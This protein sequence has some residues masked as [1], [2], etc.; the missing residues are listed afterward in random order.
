LIAPGH[1][2]PG[3]LGLDPELVDAPLNLRWRCPGRGRCTP[4]GNAILRS[5][6]CTGEERGV[7]TPHLCAKAP[8]LFVVVL[9]CLEIQGD[10][11]LLA[12]NNLLSQPPERL[13]TRIHQLGNLNEVLS[14]SLS[15]DVECVLGLIVFRVGSFGLSARLG[16]WPLR[17]QAFLS[18]MPLFPV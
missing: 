11:S 5:C 3:S 7:K 18:L 4:A 8:L 1:L 6:S 2:K 17:G 9:Q 16:L 15:V 14:H 12:R 13:E 10:A